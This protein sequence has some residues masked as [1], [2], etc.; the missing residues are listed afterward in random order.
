[1]RTGKLSISRGHGTS[2]P[3][4]SGPRLSIV[5]R[6]P[7]AIPQ[8]PVSPEYQP[9]HDRLSALERLARLRE[10]GALTD[11][12]FAAEKASILAG[13]DTLVLNEP[14]VAPEP[15]LGPT[16]LGRLFGW[17]IIPVGI[18]AG[19]ALSYASQPRETVRF[20]EEA[21]RLFGA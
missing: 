3:V 17:K 6:E 5:A 19:L 1:M 20:F 8:A 13:A 16:L 14:L 12:E 15:P 2:G 11:E 10:Q 4:A 7:A 21:A 9:V 18:A